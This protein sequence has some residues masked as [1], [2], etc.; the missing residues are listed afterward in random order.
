VEELCAVGHSPGTSIN[1]GLAE[2]SIKTGLKD[3]LYWNNI[4]LSVPIV[5]QSSLR[6]I[7]LENPVNL[8]DI[9]ATL[10]I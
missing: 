3:Y 4:P 5:H 8:E 9:F 6:E 1:F 7:P 10:Q 2:V